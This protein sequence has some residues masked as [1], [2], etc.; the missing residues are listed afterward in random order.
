MVSE[1]ALGFEENDFSSP[2]SHKRRIITQTHPFTGAFCFL[3]Q[4]SDH[5]MKELL[6]Q[7]RALVRDAV[8]FCALL[9]S[10]GSRATLESLT[11]IN[12]ETA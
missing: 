5:L 2:W 9:C 8:S 12:G 6:K 11:R 3:M 10:L 4:E 7:N 1:E